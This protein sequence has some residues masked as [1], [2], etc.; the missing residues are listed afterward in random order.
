MKRGNKLLDGPATPSLMSV[1]ELRLM[2][3]LRDLVGDVGQREAADVLGIGPQDGV[4]EP[5]RGQADAPAWPMPWS[6][7][8]WRGVARLRPG[9]GSRWMRWSG[10]STG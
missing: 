8:C 2:A 6:G 7:C 9:R 1:Q 5:G 10:G 3:L 4:E